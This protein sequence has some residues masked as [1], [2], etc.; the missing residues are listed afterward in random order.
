VSENPVRVKISFTVELGEVPARISSL[1][2]EAEL[3]LLSEAGAL[4]TG[5]TDLTDKGNLKEISD[6]IERARVALMGADMRLQDCHELLS[7]YQ[8]AQLE[9]MQSGE[10][11]PLSEE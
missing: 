2:K 11:E 8:A 9:L 6:T 1:M 4:S 10:E 3:K 7:S 5:A